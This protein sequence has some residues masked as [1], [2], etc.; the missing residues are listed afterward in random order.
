MSSYRLS[1]LDQSPI[2]AGRSPAD[3][4][5]ETLDLA[6]RVEALGYERFWVSEHHATP[7]F[8]GA[9]PE[10]LMAN[11]AART[12]TIRIGSAGV[13]L[14]HYSALKVAEQFAMLETLSPGRIDLG[15]GRA[16]GS[17]P[18][19]AIALS[20]TRTPDLDQL[21]FETK[22]R[23]LTGFLRRELPPEHAD[24]TLM[25]MPSGAGM[26]E[27]WLLGS[28][29]KSAL[30]AARLGWNFCF[31]H[32]ITGA[33]GIEVVDIYREAFVPSAWAPAPRVAVGAFVLAADDDAEAERLV[34]SAELWFLALQ[35]GRRIPFPSPETALEYT[36]TPPEAALRKRLR[37]LQ[38]HGGPAKVRR[39]LQRLETLYDTH[40]FVIVTITHSHQARVHSY[41]LLAEL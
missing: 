24:A 29:T 9:S 16:P 36:W 10:I 12:Q 3:A 20:P 2:A 32:F 37:S 34:S 1:V 31:A 22:L 8:A 13:M 15:I 19:G 17:D 23:D 6:V 40:E 41:E 30:L 26:P 21:R 18:L 14:M 28:G 11:L 5:A 27:P 35:Q 25:A 4:V 39:R 38:I 33:V 7:S